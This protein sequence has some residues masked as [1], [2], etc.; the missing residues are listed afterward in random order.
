MPKI[1]KIDA[2]GLKIHIEI[3]HPKEYGGTDDVTNG[4][5]NSV[6]N[7]GTDAEPLGRPEIN[8]KYPAIIMSHG[9]NGSCRDWLEEGRFFASKGF[10]AVSHDFCGGSSHS[11]SEGRTDEMT[12]TSEVENLRKVFEYVSGMED[13]DSS[14]IFLHGASQGG[15]ISGLLAEKLGSKIRA[16]V[17]YFPAFCIFDDWTKKY[18]SPEDAEEII[19]FWGMNLGKAFVKDV[20][21]RNV[22]SEIGK[23]PGKVLIFH[24]TE[25]ATV[26]IDYSRKASKKYRDC[27]LVEIPGEGHGFSKETTAFICEEILKFF[28]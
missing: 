27:R 20:H 28:I 19:P 21:G 24:G 17:L 4:I 10:V 13:V 1:Q 26:P 14:R 11:L 8:G 2:N 23:Y 3:Y 6:T 25:D 22:F 7:G 16:M 12:L 5:T 18:D 15:M 9:Y